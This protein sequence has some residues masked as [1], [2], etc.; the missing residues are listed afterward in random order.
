LEI[1]I[2]FKL[3]SQIYFEKQNKFGLFPPAKPGKPVLNPSKANSPTRALDEAITV[4]GLTQ[5]ASQPASRAGLESDLT[6]LR[7]GVSHGGV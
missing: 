4:A 1:G 7:D 6:L 5:P 2:H 3:K